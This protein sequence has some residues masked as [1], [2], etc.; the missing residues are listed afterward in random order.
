[1]IPIT[2]KG[3]PAQF[4]P[5]FSLLRSRHSHTDQQ[6]GDRRASCTFGFGNE[7]PRSVTDFGRNSQYGSLLQSSYLVFGGHGA[8]QLLINNFRG[9]I[10]NPC[11]GAHD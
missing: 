3:A 9:I 8:S 11:R 2:D 1:L 4:Y 7:L 5:F 6:V 10:G